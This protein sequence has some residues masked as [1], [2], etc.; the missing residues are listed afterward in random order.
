MDLYEELEQ[1]RKQ[2]DRSV[3][4]LRNTGA[5]YAECERNYKVALR[6]EVLKMRDDGQAIGVI[7]L[8]CYGIPSIAELR[9]KRDCAE[10][11]YK[12]N[13][14]A[15]NSIKLQIRIVENQIQREYTTIGD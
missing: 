7:T 1:L 14:E 4:E 10:T 8:T 11:I 5:A 9:F 15:I 3:K 12:A 13:Q 2:L 6:T